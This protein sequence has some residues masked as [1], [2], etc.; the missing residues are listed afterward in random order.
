MSAQ[1]WDPEEQLLNVARRPGQRTVKKGRWL[2]LAMFS[3]GRVRYFRLK[4]DRAATAG[5]L[6][7]AARYRQ[8][9]ARA[10]R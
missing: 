2:D 3:L 5:Y 7:W 9:M 10:P 4:G 8:Q 6:M 1:P